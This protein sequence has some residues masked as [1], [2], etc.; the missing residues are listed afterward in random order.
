M[1]T[2]DKNRITATSLSK[3]EDSPVFN[4]INS[5]SPIES[6]KSIHSGQS[7]NLLSFSSPS[8]AF[9]SPQ[10]S[11]FRESRFLPKSNQSPDPFKPEHPLCG[12]ENKESEGDSEV[13]QPYVR[14]AQQ[15]KCLMPENPAED[16]ITKPLNEFF[17]L[18]IQLSKT[19]KYGCS[20]PVNNM[21]S[22]DVVE[23]SKEPEEAART[24]LFQ[25]N[26]DNLVGTH[27]F[28]TKTNLRKILLIEQSEEVAE[29]D[30]SSLISDSSD[31]LNSNSS[32]V[33]YN[34]EEQDQT[35]V[36]PGMVSFISTAV[37]SQQDNS[38]FL[39]QMVSITPCGSSK[40]SEIREPVTQTGEIKEL[41]DLD[42]TPEF[43]SSTLL[44]KLVV[45][46]SRA[47][48][49]DKGEKCCQSSC[50]LKIRRRCLVFEKAGG[51]KKQAEN[52]SDCSSSIQL[53]SDHE[54]PY[55]G[56][57]LV[58]G[59]RESKY[60][61]SILP[62]VGLHLN[63]LAT[64]SNNSKIVKFQTPGRQVI[65]MRSSMS[66]VGFETSSQNLNDSSNLQSMERGSNPCD[67]EFKVMG[68]ALQTCSN[69]DGEEFDHTNPKRKRYKPEPD[70]ESKACKRC[71]C[72]RSKCL[73]LYCECFA[74]GLYCVEPCSCQNCF[75]KPIYEDTVMETRGQIESRNPLA[76]APKVIRSFDSV[77]DGDEIN[78]TP[79]S[80]RHKSGCNCRKSSCLKKY[81]EC[82]QGGVGCSISCRCEGC[83]NAFGRKDGADDYEDERE[84][85]EA[86]EN[87][88][89]DTNST[90]NVVKPGEEEYPD[91]LMI[92]S[93]VT[94]GKR[95]GSCLSTFSPSPKL[96]TSIKLRT[97]NLF[98]QPK[99]ESQLRVI[100]EEETLKKFES[101]CSPT[102]GVQ[103]ASPNS[104]RILP[105][106]NE[107]GSSKFRY[108]T[109]ELTLDR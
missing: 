16:V 80:A 78:K 94:R 2:P 8:S 46:D 1:D 82:F 101:N 74:A 25:S 72:K 57:Q 53:Q 42:Q 7:L 85:S 26:E 52:E 75:N 100:P 48:V 27:D 106:A 38:N 6:A 65:S 58:L 71:N 15:L 96:S 102:G 70:D 41:K 18:A 50:K 19:M 99:F 47:E 29:C 45:S 108:R 109:R 5:L 13:A 63:A 12:N 77:G 79:A 37:H 10:I 93:E 54:V 92:P 55:I 34:F 89:S 69:V 17:G 95:S 49:D 14:R 11:C 51:L 81:C 83:K 90:E 40:Q 9:A 66:S 59:K 32:V 22:H 35:T 4:Y 39:M 84:E 68:N 28:E 31:L 91:L 21:V 36:D 86:S 104:K 44:N 64:A 98:H 3:F 76:F 56:K 62:G 87:N 33:E 103:S 61:S 60:S 43:L 88:E 105:P 97:S 24:L 20:S 23:T 107:T 30:W 67:H 73:K